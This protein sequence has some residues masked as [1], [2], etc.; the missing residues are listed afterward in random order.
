MTNGLPRN[1]LGLACR[2]SIPKRSSVQP[3]QR[4]SEVLKERLLDPLRAVKEDLDIQ[5]VLKVDK[6]TCYDSN[7][8]DEL[9]HNPWQHVRL[10]YNQS[11]LF[12]PFRP[13]KRQLGSPRHRVGIKRPLW[14][15]RD[16]ANQRAR[17]MQRNA[18]SRNK[19]YPLKLSVETSNDYRHVHVMLPGRKLLML[20]RRKHFMLRRRKR[21]I[22]FRQKPATPKSLI[23]AASY[24]QL[25]PTV[26]QALRL[27][28]SPLGERSYHFR[29]A[30]LR[31]QKEDLLVGLQA[32]AEKPEQLS[33]KNGLDTSQINIKDSGTISSSNFAAGEIQ[34]STLPDKRWQ[35]LAH[36]LPLSPLMN[37]S[38]IAARERRRSP[39]PLPSKYVSGYERKLLKCPYG[40]DHRT[41]FIIQSLTNVFDS[42]SISHPGPFMFSYRYPASKILSHWIWLDEAPRDVCAMVSTI[43]TFRCS[44]RFTLS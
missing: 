10:A 18:R 30:C 36:K 34:A 21:R 32:L 3:V 28:W 41:P 33:S 14:D 15:A 12:A 42:T 22:K 38:L 25:T 35:V 40:K 17:I 43:G 7:A 44:F 13:A 2:S 37:P 24:S 1:S 9:R 31:I 8:P 4:V 19:E 26:Q 11:T 29:G 27:T 20:Q 6:N 5:G 23:L 16:V 39:K